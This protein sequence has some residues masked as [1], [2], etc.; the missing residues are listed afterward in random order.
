MME[1]AQLLSDFKQKFEDKYLILSDVPLGDGGYG[2]VFQAKDL[3]RNV[4]VAIKI[5]HNGVAPEGA[6][7][8]FAIS[9]VINTPHVATTHT[10]EKYESY[11]QKNC[12]AVISQFVPGRSLKKI[13]AVTDE[14]DDATR[15]IVAEDYAFGLVPSLLEGLAFCHDRGYGHGD[16]HDGNIMVFAQ[17]VMEQYHFHVVLIDFDN[18]SIK[19]EIYCDNEPEKIA[20]D[21]RLLKRVLDNTLMDWEWFELVEILYHGY[22]ETRLLKIAYTRVL[23]FLVHAKKHQLTQQ[24]IKGFFVTLVNS[25]LGRGNI[26]PVVTAAKRIAEKR[27]KSLEFQYAWEDFHEEIRKAENWDADLEMTI[28]EN[29]EVK[30]KVYSKIFD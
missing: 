18:A 10:I 15:K 29:S 8:G 4:I 14:Q 20:K 6:V 17:D 3:Y 26:M 12:R 5:H 13:W 30:R 11:D 22:S 19:G 25:P 9:S 28:I 16:F 21:Y 27:G 7:R 23:D 24:G 1:T 2:A